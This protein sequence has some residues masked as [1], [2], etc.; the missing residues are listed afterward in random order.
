MLEVHHCNVG[1]AILGMQE[2]ALF[3]QL[4]K[5][6]NTE[7]YKSLIQILATDMG[8]HKQLLEQYRKMC[9]AGFNKDDPVHRRTITS[10]LLKCADLSNLTKP[11]NISRLWGIAVTNEFFHQG[12][13][14]KAAGISSTPGFDR[15]NRQELAKGQLGFIDAVG[16]EFYRTV[17]S[18][19]LKGLTPFY[20]N[21]QRNREKWQQI[22][23]D[24][25][26]A[27]AK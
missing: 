17:A 11:F 13:T 19:L 7:A 18:G 25:Q 9:D 24:F 23:G 21:L 22:L 27:K 10:I 26:K 3:S 20:D 16:M 2:C 5:D 15:D 4:P 12:D 8:R 1:I 14:E 6:D